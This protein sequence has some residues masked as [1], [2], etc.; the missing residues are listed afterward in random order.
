MADAGRKDASEDLEKPVQEPVEGVR[1]EQK[2][3]HGP[4]RSGYGQDFQ[5]V[6]DGF[7]H[8]FAYPAAR[9]GGKLFLTSAAALLFH[10]APE[11]TATDA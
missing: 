6:A 1:I 7:R 3:G 10:I 5:S 4:E 8:G 11:F 9:S 2:I